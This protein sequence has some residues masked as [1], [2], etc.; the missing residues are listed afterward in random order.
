M[1]ICII[2]GIFPP[3]IGGPATYVPWLAEELW[4]LGYKV[5]VICLAC[6]PKN[7]LKYPYPV[8]RLRRGMSLPI[9]ILKTVAEIYRLAGEADLIYVNGLELEAR[10]ANYFLRK[11]II[12][13]VVCDWAWERACRWELCDDSLDD[14]QHRTDNL[15][16]RLLKSTRNYFLT[17]ASRIIVPSTH[18]ARL[19]QSWGIPENKVC[20]IPNPAGIPENLSGLD[21]KLPRPTLVTAGRLIKLKGIAAL[22]EVLADI[23]DIGLLIVGD[24]SEQLKLESLAT[25]LGLNSRVRFT[26][27]LKREEFLAYLAGADALVLNSTHEGLPHVVLEAMALGKPVLATRVGGIPEI[28]ENR[29]NGLLV[30]P[31]NRSELNK[32]LRQ[33]A[34]DKT[35]RQRLATGAKKR[36][37][38]F[39]PKTV[40]E[41]TLTVLNR[42][43]TG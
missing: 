33:L 27:R 19:V 36:G 37:Q 16:I 32:A 1:N 21:A 40:L 30:T 4:R 28:I 10:L 39:L 8:T 5:Q 12:Y 14:F 35:L 38:D 6:D 9:R 23:P 18:L 7:T 22:L 24:G 3:D 29:K 43:V 25:N 17:A 15:R 11:P 26:G 20:V 42:V 41:Q 34:T 13:K 31:G 2:S